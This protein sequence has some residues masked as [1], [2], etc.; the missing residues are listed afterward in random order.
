MFAFMC[1]GL[2]ALGMLLDRFKIGW[3]PMHATHGTARPSNK[4]VPGQL[5]SVT[6]SSTTLIDQSSK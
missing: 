2:A 5:V 6:V 3:L 4:L 1:V